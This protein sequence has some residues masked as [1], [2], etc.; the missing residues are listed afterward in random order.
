VGALLVARLDLR[1]RSAVQERASVEDHAAVTGVIQGPVEQTV[2]N[3]AAH[4]YRVI[5]VDAGG[6]KA[7]SNDLAVP[8]MT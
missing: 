6:Q 8:A 1:D 2:D 7:P 5:A 3:R 4:H